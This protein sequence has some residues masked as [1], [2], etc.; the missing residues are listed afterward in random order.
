MNL[1]KIKIVAFSAMLGLSINAKANVHVHDQGEVF[2]SQQGSMWHIEFAV[3]AINAFGFEHLPEN[4]QQQDIVK[5][6]VDS[7]SSH[8]RYIQ[9]GSDCS[10]IAS[11]EGISDLYQVNKAL[12]AHK[13]EHHHDQDSDEAT[14]LNASFS[15]TFD[16]QSGVNSI[17]LPA[18]SSLNE[19]NKL[20]VQWITEQGQGAAQVY[21]DQTELTF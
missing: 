10:L 2:I 14:H 20:S 15:F 8:K 16:C 17:K 4:L 1:T 12:P 11:N 6:F 13:H 3:P 5:G 21:N 19:L 7:L 18:F 9:L